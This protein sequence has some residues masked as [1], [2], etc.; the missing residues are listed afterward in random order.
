MSLLRSTASPPRRGGMRGRDGQPPAS[1]PLPKIPSSPSVE[2]AEATVVPGA[3]HSGKGLHW[4]GFSRRRK[5][6]KRAHLVAEEGGGD[7]STDL[8]LSH[9]TA[10]GLHRGVQ[11][12]TETG[13][14]E[15][16]DSTQRT[17]EFVFA[18]CDPLS[19]T[20]TKLLFYSFLVPL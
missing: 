7:A 15:R 14:G 12:A 5:C 9:A 18:S 10:G 4:K 8:R 20:I 16:A 17:S 19:V 11:G 3:R 6:G 1:R 2:A 13:E